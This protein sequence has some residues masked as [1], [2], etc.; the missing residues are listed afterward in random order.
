VRQG[1]LAAASSP[2]GENVSV[3]L[4]ESLSL[5]MKVAIPVSKIESTKF[6]QFQLAQIPG[7]LYPTAACTLQYQ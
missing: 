6:M 3:W 7:D 2:S 5:L 4:W 1:K